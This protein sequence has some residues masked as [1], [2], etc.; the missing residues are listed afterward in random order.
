M[1]NHLGFFSLKVTDKK[2]LGQELPLKTLSSCVFFLEERLIRFWWLS[3][4]VTV[5][6]C[7]SSSYKCNIL[8]T[9]GGNFIPSDTHIALDLNMN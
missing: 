9:I 6:S 4:K 8:V 3:V 7:L 5:T 2:L 1:L